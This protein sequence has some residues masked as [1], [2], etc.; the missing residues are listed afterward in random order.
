MDEVCDWSFGDVMGQWKQ[1]TCEILGTFALHQ[2]HSSIRFVS[3]CATGGVF[4]NN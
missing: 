1:G 4:N 3:V 2:F